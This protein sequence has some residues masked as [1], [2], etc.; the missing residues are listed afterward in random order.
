MLRI[1]SNFLNRE[2][3]DIPLQIFSTFSL[4]FFLL[5]SPPENTDKWPWEREGGGDP[6]LQKN[7]VQEGEEEREEEGGLFQNSRWRRSHTEPRGWVSIN[8]FGLYDRHAHKGNSPFKRNI[9]KKLY[10]SIFKTKPIQF[11]VSLVLI[12]CERTFLVS[13]SVELI[14]LLLS[15][16]LIERTPG[17]LLRYIKTCQRPVSQGPFL[18]P[19]WWW[20][21]DDSR[22]WRRG[23]KNS[24]AE[25]VDQIQVCMPP[26]AST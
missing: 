5:I 25:T 4:L 17:W 3:L 21:G 13:F 19:R 14:D 16:F 10:K 15:L 24:A 1:H 26:N 11:F 20:R 7:T 6:E 23:C 18:T 2:S 9:S 12:I 22:S 8:W